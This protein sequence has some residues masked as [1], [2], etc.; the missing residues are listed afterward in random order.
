MTAHTHAISTIPTPNLSPLLSTSDSTYSTP[1]TPAVTVAVVN[2]YYRNNSLL[3]DLAPPRTPTRYTK[4][5]LHGFGYLIPASIPFE[6]NPERALGV[7]FDSDITPDPHNPP[8]GWAKGTRLTVMLGGHWWDGW[9]AYPDEEE[10]VDM[11]QAVLRRHLG[12]EEAPEVARCKVQRDCIPQYTVGFGERMQ[13]L[14][15]QLRDDFDGRLRVAGCWVGGVGVADCIRGGYE[16]ARG[17]ADGNNLTGLEGVV[18]DRKMALLKRL[19]G[20]GTVVTKVDAGSGMKVGL[21]EGKVE[22]EEERR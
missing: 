16:A 21:S 15:R 2:L 7:I 5:G 13:G 11:A 3:Q 8:D 6:Q 12:I 17:L 19:P 9:S 1:L 4:N 10:C 18:D 22:K 20:G 14:H